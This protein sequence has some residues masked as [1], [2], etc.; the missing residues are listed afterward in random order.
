MNLNRFLM[1][2]I[3]P[4]ALLLACGGH[5]VSIGS[6]GEEL[7]TYDPSAVKVATVACPAGY[8]HPNIC[9]E[10]GGSGKSAQ[11]E[12][13][14]NHPFHACAQG[15][16]PYPNALACCSLS[17]A[18][19]CIECDDKGNCGQ[20]QP[21]APPVD[22]GQC[23]SACPPGYTGDGP[24]S[25]GG[26]CT[27]DPATNLGSCF[28]NAH[29]DPPPDVEP[30]PYPP[31]PE[32]AGPGPIQDA[33]VDGGPAPPLD[34]G[35]IDAGPYPVDGGSGGGCACAG[36]IPI[37]Q[38]AGTPTDPVP[39]PT[40]G[41]DASVPP[42]CDCPIEPPPPIC[43]NACPPSWTQ[44]APGVC[45]LAAPDGSSECFATPRAVASAPTPGSSGGS[46]GSGGG[47]VAVPPGN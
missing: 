40:Y 20:D 30:Q 28:A 9:C 17:N 13:Y 39:G 43:D 14:V 18:G 32:D 10:G 4:G 1:G 26:C 22:P 31:P 35:V 46:S 33:S 34:G 2:L 42:V 36:P 16:T 12:A 41:N 25:P 8:Q 24:D 23:P 27:Y 29:S 21:P 38:D 19:E 44:T 47:T 7:K 11:C 37:P 6:N 45:C 5:V 3:A 15:W